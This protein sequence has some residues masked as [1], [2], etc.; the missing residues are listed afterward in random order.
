[1]ESWDFEDIGA[2]S[3]KRFHIEFEEGLFNT[4]TDDAGEANFSL[5]DVSG[6]QFQLQARWLDYRHGRQLRVDWSSVDTSRYTV[7]PPPASLPAIS[8]I[9]SLP[10]AQLPASIGWSLNGTCCMMIQE[11]AISLPSTPFLTDLGT[12]WMQYYEDVIGNLTPME[13]SLP[14]THDSGTYQMESS[15]SSP[16]TRTQWRSL[17][18]QLNSGIR[19]LDLRI[20]QNSPGDYVIV[21]DKYRTKYSLSRALKEVTDFISATSKEIVVLDFHRFKKLG[22]DSFDQGQLQSQVKAALQGFY[23]PEPP[24]SQT[25]NELWRGAAVGNQ[26]VIIAWNDSSIDRSYMWPGVAQSWYSE[27]GSIEELQECVKNDFSSPHS[28]DKFWAAC[29]FVNLAKQIPSTLEGLADVLHPHID[30]WF[31]GCDEWSLKANIVSTDFCP[32]TNNMI[33]ACICASLLKGGKK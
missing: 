19:V 29:V 22:S 9:A 26:R 31:H 5:S 10:S 30:N 18:Q 6:T 1:M 33:N 17:R 27:A 20:G 32:D 13:M 11:K 3:N 16:W 14:G 15:I 7:F 12:G 24:R 21:H 2:N 28:S 8:S 4:D 23:L 25:L